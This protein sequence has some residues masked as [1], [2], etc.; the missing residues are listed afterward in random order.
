MKPQWFETWFDSPYY[1]KLYRHRD[2]TEARQFIDALLRFL[3]PLRG[4]SFLDVAC[5][6]GRHARYLASLGYDVTGVD[7][8]K[9]NIEYAKRFETD[10]LKFFIRDI[11]QPLEV[12]TFDCVL[13]LFTSFGYF[14]TVQEHDDA[15]RNMCACLNPG[16]RFVLDFMNVA[17]VKKHLVKSEKVRVGEVDFHISRSFDP[18]FITKSIKVVHDSEQ[19]TFTERV[20]AFTRDDLTEMLH[21]AGLRVL[22]CFGNYSLQ[23]FDDDQPRVIIIAETRQ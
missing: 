19:K 18:P 8:S 4:A 7:L 17:Y 11:R 5:G 12:G 13:N 14:D 10:N 23:P 20:Y 15:L 2:E 22:N 3:Q 9:R 6:K 16:G 21:K 1:H